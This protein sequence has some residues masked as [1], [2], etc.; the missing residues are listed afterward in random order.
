MAGI[1]DIAKQCNVSIGTVSNILNG[2]GKASD[3]TRQLVM[4]AVRELNYKPNYMAKN[5]KQR[6]RRTIGEMCI[7]DRVHDVHF[8]WLGW[9]ER[10][11]RRQAAPDPA[12]FSVFRRKRLLCIPAAAI[13]LHHT[14][15]SG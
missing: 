4:E 3:A 6:Q 15:G 9:P 2:K 8:L 5:L 7:R 10:R 12:R 1:K 13:F 11:V 14:Q